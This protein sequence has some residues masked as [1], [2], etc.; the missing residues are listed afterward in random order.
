MFTYRYQHLTIRQQ[1]WVVYQNIVDEGE[2]RV[3]YFY[4]FMD[5]E[6]PAKIQTANAIEIL[7][8]NLAL[9]F[10]RES[11]EVRIFV[12]RHCTKNIVHS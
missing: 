1:G 8:Q 11:H 9:K 2:A 12:Q 6:T 5:N 4:L 7:K 3:Y 10:D